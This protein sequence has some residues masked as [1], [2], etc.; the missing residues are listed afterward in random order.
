MESIRGRFFLWLMLQQ[1][2]SSA[3]AWCRCDAKSLPTFEKLKV[4]PDARHVCSNGGGSI[5]ERIFGDA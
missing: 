1:V 5:V 2:A 3:F 4:K